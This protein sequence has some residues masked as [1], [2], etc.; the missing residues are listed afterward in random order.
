MV[1]LAW[2]P[3]K[4]ERQSLA[5]KK[6]LYFDI[7]R[8]T[9]Q[10]NKLV[11]AESMKRLNHPSSQPLTSCFLLISEEKY[12]FSWDF[13][14]VFV[15][16]QNTRFKLGR[17]KEGRG[18]IFN[19]QFLNTI[20]QHKYL[21]NCGKNLFFSSNIWIAIK[22]LRKHP[23]C[24][25][26]VSRKSGKFSPFFSLFTLRFF[27]IIYIFPHK[28]MIKS[29]SSSHEN[30]RSWCDQ[31]TNALMCGLAFGANEKV[32]HISRVRHFFLVSFPLWSRNKQHTLLV[33][34]GKLWAVG[35]IN[36]ATSSVLSRPR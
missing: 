11:K 6:K 23:Q 26:S 30:T 14:L 1:S 28:M 32:H 21:Q 35:I 25:P 17:E 7:F 13:W 33:Y 8:R 27:R 29:S 36:S 4:W 24:A 2:Q 18:Y 22:V 9:Q 15:L 12:G 5:I 19:W 31:Q 16:L 3:K 10:R 34:V 20:I